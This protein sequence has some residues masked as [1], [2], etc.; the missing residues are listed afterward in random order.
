MIGDAKVLV[1]GGS[2]EAVD[3]AERLGGRSTPAGPIDVTYSLAGRTSRPRL[4]FPAGDP[5]APGPFPAGYPGAP[6]PFPAGRSRVG[7]FGGVD[8][9]E[10]WLADS[11]VAA[12]MDATH[13]FAASMPHHAAEACARLSVPRLRLRR[14]EWAPA[15]GDRWTVVADLSDAARTVADLGARRVFL[16]TGRQELVA[17]SGLHDVWFLVRTIEAPQPQPLARAEVVAAR[18]PFDADAEQALMTTHGVDLLVTKNSGGSA[19]APKLVAARRLGLPVVVVER[20]ATPAGPVV[21]TVDAAVEW[22]AATIARSVESR[23]GPGSGPAG[24]SS[25]R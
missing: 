6:G 10:R 2:S 8:G 15:P 23:S 3:L 14:P 20:P 24:L 13:P 18:G 1:L 25:G 19:A 17:F 5:G 4:P 22:C 7:G 21:T 16:T 9:L 11:G 12:V